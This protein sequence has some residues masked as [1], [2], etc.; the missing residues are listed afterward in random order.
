MNFKHLM[1]FI[2][3]IWVMFLSLA[4]LC[5]WSQARADESNTSTGHIRVQVMEVQTVK[6]GDILTFSS[7]DVLPDRSAEISAW[8]AIQIEPAAGNAP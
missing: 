4:V 8:R 2:I 7:A 3:A 6:D 5:I 1:I